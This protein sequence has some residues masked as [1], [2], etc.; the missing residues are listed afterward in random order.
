MQ[1]ARQRMLPASYPAHPI[2]GMC[3]VCKHKHASMHKP[4]DT[5]IQLMAVLKGR[6]QA[7]LALPH[8][9]PLCKLAS[10]GV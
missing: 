9:M 8:P 4:K 6:Q 2:M 3:D 7:L 5:N 1:Y 10:C